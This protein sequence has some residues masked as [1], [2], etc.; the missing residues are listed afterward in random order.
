MTPTATE[1]E[2]REILDRVRKLP[3]EA[4]EDIVNELLDELE[5]TGSPYTSEAVRLAWKEEIARRIAAFERGEM[6]TMTVEESL[7]AIDAA[8]EE[9]RRAG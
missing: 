1:Q 9:A 8:L 5:P 4:R 3:P 6:E 7:A 2:V